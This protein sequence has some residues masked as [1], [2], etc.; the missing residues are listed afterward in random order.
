MVEP[1]EL[2][3]ENK[4]NTRSKVLPIFRCFLYLTIPQGGDRAVGSRRLWRGKR[5]QVGLEGGVR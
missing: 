3:I 4:H 1:Y 2:N 5:V